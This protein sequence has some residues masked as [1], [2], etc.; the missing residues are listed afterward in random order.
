MQC[1]N[2]Q[3]DSTL[4]WIVQAI[5][6]AVQDF[7]ASRVDESEVK[8]IMYEAVQQ[9]HEASVTFSYAPSNTY[10]SPAMPFHRKIDTRYLVRKDLIL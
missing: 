4:Q 1:S 8:T 7:F 3:E 5:V 2:R 6:K 10:T 9:L